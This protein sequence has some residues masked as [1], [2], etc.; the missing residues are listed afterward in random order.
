MFSMM[1]SLA[2]GGSLVLGGQSAHA[3]MATPAP[4]PIQTA[5]M[6]TTPTMTAPM[7]P[8]T[9][10]AYPAATRRGLFGRIRMRR[11][12][13]AYPTTAT[14]SSA[15]PGMTYAPATMNYAQPMTSYT[16][17]YGR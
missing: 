3:Q 4:M 14:Y 17:M 10:Y 15:Q 5:P 1:G 16:R 11:Q 2:V 8:G 6:M 7:S 12:A 13:Y 9:A